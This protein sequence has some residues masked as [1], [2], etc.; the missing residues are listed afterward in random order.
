MNKKQLLTATLA[1]LS[2][3]EVPPGNYL[4]RCCIMDE[5][6]GAP[7]QWENLGKYGTS[8]WNMATAPFEYNATFGMELGTSLY[9]VAPSQSKMK[10]SY[11]L[12]FQLFLIQSDSAPKM[13]EVGWTVLP[14]C[15]GSP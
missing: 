5:I 14:L 11:C 8:K 13:R 3:I 1:T 2:I 10:P 15:D 12:C 4:L 7:L 6:C 9:T